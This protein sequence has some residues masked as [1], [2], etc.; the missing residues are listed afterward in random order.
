MKKEK[1]IKYGK[2][3]LLVYTVI[4]LCCVCSISIV[5]RAAAAANKPLKSSDGM[6]EYLAGVDGH[7]TIT[8][9]IG[10]QAVVAI[11]GKI[12]GMVVSAVVE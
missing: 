6:W 7:V 2:C 9:Y 8:K 12:E 3:K 10:D 5:V 11:P 1:N 4:L